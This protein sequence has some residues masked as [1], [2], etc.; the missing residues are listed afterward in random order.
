MKKHIT[1]VVALLL[2]LSFNGWAGGKQEAPTPEAEKQAEKTVLPPM[3]KIIY[4]TADYHDVPDVH[5]AWQDAFKNIT[6]VDVELKTVSSKDADESMVAMLMGGEKLD[7]IKYGGDD[8]NAL[9]RQEFIIPLDKFIENSPEMKKLK[10]MFPSSF[11]AHSWN[12]VVYGIPERSGSNRGLWVRTDILKKLGLSM[13]GTL[14]EFVDTLKKIRDN[15]PAA[16]GS[17]MF[18][19][20]S[21][22]YHHGYIAVLSNYFNV[23]IDPAVRRPGDSKYREG[24]DTPQFRDYAEFMKMLWNEQLID[25]DHALPQK[26]SKTRSKLY[27]GKGAFLAMWT[28]RYPGMIQELRENFP[29]AELVLV[30]P[31]KNPN[32]GVLGLSV[33]PGYRPFCITSMAANPQFVWD[34]FIETVI[35]TTEG[36][37]L[38]S[39]GIP[40]ISYKVVDNTFEDNFEES[41]THMK[42]RPPLNPNIKFPYKLPPLMQRGAELEAQFSQWFSENSAYAVAEEPSVSVPAFDMIHDDMKDKKNQLF[43]KYVMGEHS[44]EEMMK[45]FDSYK[46]EIDFDSILAEING[47]L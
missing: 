9:A 12:G 30:P 4:L 24:W 17:R 8:I 25:P 14:D 32:G 45:Q 29:E 21:K 37:M 1:A 15:Y 38:L 18:P 20:I 41:G 40:G 26:S 27:A 22:T 33:V 43:W 42:T 28:Y 2:I 13:P 11:A 35:L 3:D 7:V 23:S 34:K 6:N 46:K 19:Y 10:N 5:D 47:K 44:F 31:I 16:D 39:R 36:S